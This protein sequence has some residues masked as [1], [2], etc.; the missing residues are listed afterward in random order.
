MFGIALFARF[1]FIESFP[2]MC[3]EGNWL[4]NRLQADKSEARSLLAVDIQGN[5]RG[6][7]CIR[8]VRWLISFP[9]ALFSQSCAMH[10]FSARWTGKGDQE[11]EATRRQEE[12]LYAVAPGTFSSIPD[13]STCLL[14]LPQCTVARVCCFWG[15]FS[16]SFK[17]APIE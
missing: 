6:G 14:L 11:T 9:V 15:I 3:F 10:P 2:Q 16:Q 1:F 4:Q 12:K 7:F 17:G 8:E 5:Q 13:I